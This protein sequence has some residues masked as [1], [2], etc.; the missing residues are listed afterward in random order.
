M[1]SEMCIRDRSTTDRNS[2][3]EVDEVQQSKEVKEAIEEER[4]QDTLEIPEKTRDL[5]II[6]IP[7][8]PSRPTTTPIDVTETTTGA[9]LFEDTTIKQVTRKNSA[10][11]KK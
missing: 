6:P 2:L 1:G 5:E 3:N 9:I 11:Y 4:S 7:P 8:R 10:A